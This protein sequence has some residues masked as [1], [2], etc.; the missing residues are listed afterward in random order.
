MAKE[1]SSEYMENIYVLLIAILCNTNSD[2]AFELYYKMRAK[3][4]VTDFDCLHMKKLYE[5]N[6]PVA[7]IAIYYGTSASYIYACISKINNKLFNTLQ[8]TS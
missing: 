2:H 7:E 1:I 3:S 4:T 5:K 6:V 8:K